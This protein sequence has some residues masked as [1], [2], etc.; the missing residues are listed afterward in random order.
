[1]DAQEAAKCVFVDVP[2]EVNIEKGD[3]GWSVFTKH[4]EALCEFMEKAIW[5]IDPE[6]DI[7]PHTLMPFC[8]STPDGKEDEST[9]K[10]LMGML[11]LGLQGQAF[12]WKYKFDFD[13]I[14]SEEQKAYLVLLN[15]VRR[16]WNRGSETG[17]KIEPAVAGGA[18]AGAGATTSADFKAKTE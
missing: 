2:V 6:A 9:L 8:Y 12:A 16:M 13:V 11:T 4:M 1:M 10:C 5:P 3:N 7:M 15:S 14:F 17:K 18:G